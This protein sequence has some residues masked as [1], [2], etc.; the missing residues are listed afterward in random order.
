MQQSSTRSCAHIRG[1]AFEVVSRRHHDARQEPAGALRLARRPVDA[2]A[3]R[4][5]A[6]NGRARSSRSRGRARSRPAS[7]SSAIRTST[8]A[9]R[10][11]RARPRDLADDPAGHLP[12]TRRRQH[13]DLGRNGTYLVYREMTQKV[14]ALWDYLAKQ[15]REPGDTTPSTGRSRSARRWS[16]AGRA[17]RRSSTSPR[18]R[19]SEHATTT[20]SRTPTDDAVGLAC[21]V[22]AHIRRANPRDALG[23][24]RDDEASV[25]MVR[26]HQMVRRGRPFGPPVS[27]TLE[28]RRDPRGAGR[29]REAARPPLHLPRRQHQP[30]VR[31]RAAQLDPVGELRRAVQGRRSAL[32]RGAARTRTRTTSSRARR[33]RCA[34]S[35]RSMPQFTHARR[36]RLL[37]PAGHRGAAVHRAGIRDR[38]ARARLARAVRGRRAD[39]CVLAIV[40][41]RAWRSAGAR[42]RFMPQRHGVS[43]RADRA[44][45]R[46]GAAARRRRRACGCRAP[47]HDENSPEPSILGLAIEARQRSGSAARELRVVHRRRARRRRTTDVADYLGN[48]FVVGDAVARA[49]ARHRV[50]A[51]A[52]PIRRRTSRRPATRVERLDCRHRGRSREVHARG[53]RG[54]GP[55]WCAARADRRAAPRRAAARRRS[56]LPRSRC[57]APAA[58][59]VPT[60]LRNGIRV[61]DYPVSQLARRLR[62]GYGRVQRDQ[63]IGVLDLLGAQRGEP[64]IAQRRALV[65]AEQLAEPDPR[66]GGVQPELGRIARRR[67]PRAARAR[68]P[69]CPRAPRGCRRAGARRSHRS[70]PCPR[71]RASRCAARRS[72]GSCSRS[73]P[74]V[75]ASPPRARCAP[76]ARGPRTARSGPSSAASATSAPSP[77]RRACAP[78]ARRRRRGRAARSSAIS[79]QC[80]I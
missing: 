65:A 73:L 67:S 75:D 25:T 76:A 37:L 43:R 3:A 14:H 10:T 54:A 41:L 35:T 69:R 49:R 40:D 28:P 66:G 16:G 58:A 72:R 47:S 79:F 17:A 80:W 18:A 8:A 59:C 55:R 74:F 13:K 26:K 42:V 23:A 27:T 39:R 38:A 4:R 51:R 34:A 77:P 46:R 22:G 9:A 52:F 6:A 1:G 12:P 57:C 50:A 7:S 48:Q 24:G 71:A 5:A 19:R 20:R 53:A 30:P 33:C 68:H 21:P 32:G 61:I 15:S 29:R 64:G 45:R 70:S 36:R 44:R 11:A 63:A 56:G 62:G 2:E 31:V 60:G 78:R